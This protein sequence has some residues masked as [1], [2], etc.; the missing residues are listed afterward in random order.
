MAQT[1][2][3]RRANERF[4]KNEAAKRGRGPVSKAKPNSKA[5]VSASWVVILAFVVCGGLV[6]EL[7]R[8]VPELWSTVTSTLSRLT[9]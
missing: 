6:L 2:Q 9:G 7:L 3:Q 4:A 1:P 8:I 5:P